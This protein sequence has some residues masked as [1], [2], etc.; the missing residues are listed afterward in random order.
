[1]RNSIHALGVVF[2]G[3]TL[4]GCAPVEKK[5]DTG[6]RLRTRAPARACPAMPI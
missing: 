4:A 2:L 3:L 5:S 1:M 6:K